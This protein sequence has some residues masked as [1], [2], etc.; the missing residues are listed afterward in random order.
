[1][2][3]LTLT[4]PADYSGTLNLSVTAHAAVNGTSADTTGS[5]AVTVG[6]VADAPSL[7][8]VPAVGLED[9][10]IALTIAAGLHAPATGETLSV[11]IAGVPAGATLSAGTDNHDGSWTLTSAQLTGL[12]LTPPTDYSGTLNLSVTAHAAVNGTTADTTGSLAVTVGAVADAPSL[13]VVPAVGLE[14]QPIALTIAAGLHAPADGE[15]L[16]VTIAGVPAGATLSAGTDNHDGSWTLTGAQLTGLTLTPPADYSGTLNLSVTAHAAVNGTSADTTGSLAV[17][18]GAVADAPSLAVVPAVGL[19]DQPI[20]LTIAAGLHAPADG[21]T[22]SV[23]IA[24]VPAG[25]T[26]S[27]GTDNHDGTWTLTGAQ[28]TG[29]TITPPADYSGTLNLSVTAHAA[30]NGTI[31]DTTGSLAVTVGAV[32]DAP[33]LAVVPAVG[34]EDQPIALT[35]AA[36]LHAPATGETLSVTIAGVPA[37][38][39]LNHGTDNGDGTWTLTGAQLTGLTLTPPADYSGT[40]NLSV[41]AHAAVNGSTADTTGSLAVTVGAV[42]DAPSLAVVPAVGL[43][44]QPIALTIAAGLHAP[45][46]GETLSVTISGVPAGA[47]LNHGTDNGDGSWTLT[48]AQLT[49]LTITPPADYSGTLNLSVTAHAAVN[50]TSADTTGS[51]AVTVGAVADAPSL[52]VVPAVGLEDQ[53]I[54]LTI[55]AGLHAPATGET[56]SV[57][58]AGVPAGATLNHGTDNGDGT[59]TLTGAQLTG[60]TLTPPADYSGTLNLSVTAHAAVNGTTADTTGS[61]AVTVGAVADAPSLAVVPAVGLEDQPIALTIAAGLHAPATG[62][63]LSVTIAGVPAGA[64]LNH[65][66]DNGDGSW[67]LTGAQLTGLTITPPADYSGTLNLSV[68]AHAA[69]NG[70]TAD[71]S[72]SLAVTV[73]AVADAPSLAVV[74]AVGLEDQ[75]IALTIAAGLHAPATGETLSVT[76][77]GVPAGA[78]LSAG[79]DNHDGTWTLTGAQLTGLTITPPADYSGTLNLSVTAHAAVNGSTADTTGSLAVTVGAVADAPSLAVVP[80]VGLE[81]QP[82]ALT[83]AAGLHGPADGETLSVTI[84]GVPAG[85]TLNHGT[86][87]GDGSWTLTGAQLTGLTLT[88]PADYSGTLNLSVTAHAAVNGST[89]DTT[90]SLAVTVGAVADAPSLAVVPAVGLE[91]QPIALTIAAGLHAPADGETLSVTIAG[92]PAGATL[93]AGTDNHDGTWTLT[94]AQLTGLTLTPPTDYSGT[95]NLSVTAHAA[96]NGTT[97]DTTGSLAVTVGAVA[98]APSLAVVPAVGLEDQPIALTIAAG[99][100]APATGETLS[101]TIAGV[102]A[103]ATL[104]AGTDNHDGTWT[105][106]GAQLTGLTITPPADYS[107]TLNLSVTAH[108]AVN[109]TTADTTGS[110]AVT[111]GAVA[112]APSLAVVPAVGLE[113][114]PI[115]L[116]IAAGLHTPADGETLSVT[117]A[118]VPAGAT[119]SAGTDNHD[120]TWTLTGA[121]LTGPD[122][123]PAGRLQRDSES[124][125]DGTCRRQRHDGR[126]HR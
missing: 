34:L 77:A 90:G 49:G 65:G 7:A 20:A 33:S 120:G 70:T 26:L 43:E 42:A 103:G 40:L 73:G 32:A 28:L 114:Q 126:H 17:T 15:T 8:V 109:G 29:L 96:V 86:D 6:A 112:D 119:L 83:I 9:Q 12:T 46:D 24:G 50:G 78:T 72:G 56:L 117:I 59:W 100:H 74:P 67:T 39:T 18:V 123:H 88:P 121:Q 84:A 60:L 110:L 69:V 104:S 64:T 75:P 37:G 107:G 94:G 76:I 22:L 45:A 81:D 58:I 105:L 89:A 48:G 3:G 111:V 92:V 21:E 125:R 82:I 71:T 87:N 80:A 25:A 62:E 51:L 63:T 101:V 108:A 54:A 106:T 23:T 61:L 47:T 57:T 53:P 95:L 79:T 41:T 4:P 19:E 5:L 38:A 68:T 93:S 13:A 91:D 2:S 1:M 113:D 27:A 11:T 35:I 14:D 116:T 118:G 98:D 16:S 55:A 122:P 115:A 44:D 30:V 66:T 99:L 31:A 85:A 102:P 52:A 10:P 97:A 36:G 124:V